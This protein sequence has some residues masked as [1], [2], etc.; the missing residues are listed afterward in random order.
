MV[1][2][3]IGLATGLS[4]LGFV[5]ASAGHNGDLDA[6]LASAR[7]RIQRHGSSPLS[8][9]PRLHNLLL[10][11]QGCADENL[12]SA[13][14]EDRRGAINDENSRPAA[15]FAKHALFVFPLSFVPHLPL[16]RN[17]SL[18]KNVLP[19]GCEKTLLSS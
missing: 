4:V 14:W 3:T 7:V 6:S 13:R 10:D 19:T 2:R 8:V 12:D 1:Q 11:S 9:S 17:K 15:I 16:R 18:F 5:P